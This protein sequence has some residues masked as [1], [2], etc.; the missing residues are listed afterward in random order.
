VAPTGELCVDSS[1][2][3][4]DDTIYDTVIHEEVCE[5]CDGIDNDNDGLIDENTSDADGDGTCDLLDICE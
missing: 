3:G 1:I 5:V 2:Y 4:E